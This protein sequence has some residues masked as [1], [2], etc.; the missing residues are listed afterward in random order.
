ML[1]IILASLLMAIVECMLLLL[2]LG[3]AVVKLLM[4]FGGGT[5]LILVMLFRP[6]TK[7]MIYK[8]FLTAY[9]VALLFGGSLVLLQRFF[10]MSR[11]T[12]LG[13]ILLISVFAMIIWGIYYIAAGTKQEGVVEAEL[14]FRDGKKKKLTALI[15]TGN[16]LREP[17]SQRPV[18]LIWEEELKDYKES[19]ESKDFRIVPFSSVGREKGLLKG[20]FIK[21]III[22]GKKDKYIYK[23]AM[24]ALTKEKLSQ[25]SNYQIIL[26]PDLIKE[27]EAEQ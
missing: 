27:Q 6:K 16:S 13:L 12:L 5:V 2:P 3:N 19:F 18:S 20:Y 8:I 17:V 11:V 22:Y 10:S 4:G 14:C 25:G 21:E 9:T 24:V 23:N 7:Y 15:D 26:H 1:K